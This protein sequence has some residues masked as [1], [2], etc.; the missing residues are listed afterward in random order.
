MLRNRDAGMGTF[1]TFLQVQEHPN[2][3]L[4]NAP[5]IYKQLKNLHRGYWVLSHKQTTKPSKQHGNFIVFTG[6][7]NVTNRQTKKIRTRKLFL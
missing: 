7:W 3:Q 2:N 1:A 4:C 5:L 6:H